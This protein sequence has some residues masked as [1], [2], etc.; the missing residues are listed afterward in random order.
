MKKK[1]SAIERIFIENNVNEDFKE[2]ISSSNLKV[3]K[4][5]N[6]LNKEIFKYNVGFYIVFIGIIIEAILTY[7]YYKLGIYNVVKLIENYK[8]DILSNK[9]YNEKV[10]KFKSTKKKSSSKI[11]NNSLN[12]S[13]SLNPPLKKEK[14]KNKNKINQTFKETNSSKDKKEY[15]K[16]FKKQSI[17]GIEKINKLLKFSN[18]QLNE[19]NY[20]DSLKYDN[21]NILQ[22]YYSF[23][24][25]SQLIIFSFLN[26]TDYNVKV[27]KIQL[28]VFAI[29]IFIVFNTLFYSDKDVSHTYQ[30]QGKFDILYTL[31]KTIFSSVISAV[32]NFILKFLSLSNEKIKQL[33]NIK[34]I[35]L[36]QK[37]LCLEIQ[38]IK[39][40]IFVFHILIFLFTLF[41]WFYITL[42]CAVYRNSQIIVFKSCIITFCLSMFYPFIICFATSVFRLFALSHEFKPIFYISKI[43]QLF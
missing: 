10:S 11:L 26:N 33:A 7:Y 8:Y 39:R 12:K 21:R 5:L 9:K 24:M 40:K 30:N 29:I 31:P 35:K 13:Y 41:F 37:K 22:I 19:M 3:L 18:E 2:K 43:F 23:L 25:Y 1:T 38:I 36:F 6:L 16:L 28:F 4:C 17:Q 32:I 34:N 14:P 42:F 27:L 20:E 15:D